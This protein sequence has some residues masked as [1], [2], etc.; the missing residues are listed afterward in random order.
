[1][2]SDLKLAH[3]LEDEGN[4]CLSKRMS[5][6]KVRV[7]TCDGNRVDAEKVGRWTPQDITSILQ[8]NVKRKE[9]LRSM[10]LNFL[11]NCDLPNN[12]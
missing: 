8:K 12:T 1:M 5:T 2:E 7:H 10:K 4:E 11:Y 9:N 3:K 6:R